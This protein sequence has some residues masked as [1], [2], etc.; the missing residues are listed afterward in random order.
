[1]IYLFYIGR[2]YQQGDIGYFGLKVCNE[3]GEIFVFGG[4]FLKYEL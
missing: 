1:M 4:D 3:E 2:A